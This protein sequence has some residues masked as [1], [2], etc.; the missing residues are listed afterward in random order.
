[1]AFLDRIACHVC[2]SFDYNLMLRRWPYLAGLLSFQG[3]LLM[4]VMQITFVHYI[5]FSMASMKGIELNLLIY[6]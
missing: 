4:F 6:V 3:P 5:L 1:M 2:S